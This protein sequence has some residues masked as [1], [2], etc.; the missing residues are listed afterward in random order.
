L[1]S[2]SSSLRTQ[3][4]EAYK[5]DIAGLVAAN[6]D[7]LPWS[8]SFLDGIREDHLADVVIKGIIDSKA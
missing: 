1:S 5:S 4:P 3:A 7:R 2:G 8:E 6:H